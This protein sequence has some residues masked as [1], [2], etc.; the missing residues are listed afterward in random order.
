VPRPP[1]ISGRA[2]RRQRRSRA[3]AASNVAAGRCVSVARPAWPPRVS[4]PLGEIATP[5]RPARRLM[6]ALVMGRRGAPWSEVGRE[7]AEGVVPEGQTAIL[8]HMNRQDV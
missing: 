8:T 6:S 1:T 2:M 3:E 7:W 5:G 4:N